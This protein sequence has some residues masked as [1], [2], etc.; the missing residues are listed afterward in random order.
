MTV[1]LWGDSKPL[2]VQV[3]TA[4]KHFK[5]ARSWGEWLSLPI[6]YAVAPLSSQ[7]AITLWDLSAARD[8]AGLG[9]AIPFG[10][11]TIPLFDKDSTL[12]KGRQ[13][14]HLHLHKEADGLSNT[15]TPSTIGL[16]REERRNG[17]TNELH[18]DERDKEMAR[19][20]D[21]MK[22]HEMGEIPQ[23]EWLD[24]LVFREIEK[25]ER[26]TIRSQGKARKTRTEDETRDGISDGD[27]QYYL[28]IEF[29]RFDHPIVFTD[30]EYPAPPISTLQH[31]G[32]GIDLK[33][34]RK[35]N[36]GQ[37]SI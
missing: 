6:N 28:Y 27:E 7:L 3:Q 17:R 4:Y 5:S 32:S 30:H 31:S 22:K 15:T 10:G 13:R 9:H 25:L 35:Y 8:E 24:N 12:Q 14:C 36:L 34:P 21:L 2:P 23:N 18:E 33:P 37:A 1:Q 16:S 11:T 29:P 19:L 26:S 20:E